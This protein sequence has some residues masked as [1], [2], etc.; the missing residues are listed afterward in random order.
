MLP[1]E[2]IRQR[3]TIS[4]RISI[5]PLASKHSVELLETVNENRK[6]LAGYL[7]WTDF[8]TNRRE[9]GDYISRRINSHAVDAYWFAIYFDDRFT[10][11]IGS[12]GVEPETRTTEIAYW[13]ADHGRGNRLIDQ[14]LSVLILYL[15]KKGNARSIQFHCLEENIP[16][17]R[18][19]ERTGA[20]LKHYLDHEFDMLDRSQRLG[21]YE[22]PLT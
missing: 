14:A 1:D 10:G 2:D 15:K 12:K 8:V 22:L 13:L 4:E 21:V 5:E 11:V 20:K 16:S 19:A 6:R 7:P 17:I 9:A 3:F 18:I